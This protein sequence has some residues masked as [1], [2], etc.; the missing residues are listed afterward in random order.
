MHIGHVIWL[1]E[2]SLQIVEAPRGG[3]IEPVKS[4]D[5]SY[6]STIWSGTDA[7]SV[8]EETDIFHGAVMAAQKQEAYC[9]VKLAH[10]L[11]KHQSLKTF[12]IA[13][14]ERCLSSWYSLYLAHVVGSTESIVGAMVLGHSLRDHGT[15]KQLAVL[16]TLDTVSASAIDHLKVCRDEYNDRAITDCAQRQFSTMLCPLIGS[17]TDL[18]PTCT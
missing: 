4:L 12:T 5:L 8:Q 9:T 6:H 7:L 10:S 15:Q 18:P 2:K 1:A 13:S 11:W 16:V 14:H 17:S 3:A